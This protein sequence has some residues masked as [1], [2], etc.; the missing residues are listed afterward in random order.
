MAVKLSGFNELGQLSKVPARMTRQFLDAAWQKK[1]PVMVDGFAMPLSARIGPFLVRLCPWR[2]AKTPPSNPLNANI[3]EPHVSSA[4]DNPTVIDK[5]GIGT[6]E[7]NGNGYYILI[8]N[9][10]AASTHF[11]I[12]RPGKEKDSRLAQLLN[13][14]EIESSKLNQILHSPTEIEAAIL[15]HRIFPAEMS[16]IF[17]SNPGRTSRA[18]ASQNHFHLHVL[19]IN[20]YAK[21]LELQFLSKFKPLNLRRVDIGEL[22][23]WPAKTRVFQGADT[24]KIA[25]E[26]YL[27][28]EVLHA[29]NNAY[30][31]VFFRYAGGLERIVVVPRSLGKALTPFKG[32]PPTNLGADS[33]VGSLVIEDNDVFAMM[34]TFPKEAGK[35]IRQQLQE[36]TVSEE[37]L[38]VFDQEYVFKH[39]GI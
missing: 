20:D 34:L 4:F 33:Q 8:N 9:N 14:P 22:P 3:K 19:A 11:L 39:G 10:P 35:V 38:S 12:I 15:M 18:G 24:G 16:F 26:V 23:E 30:N 25:K 37:T 32:Y 29:A 7:I 2:S 13:E 28:I 21:Y 36:T 17:N 1:L 31:V 27:Y 6:L 5:T